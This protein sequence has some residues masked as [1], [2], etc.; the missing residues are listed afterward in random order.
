VLD[1]QGRVAARILGQ[2]QSASILDA[3]VKTVVEED[4]R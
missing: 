4:G 1:G 3:I 2:L